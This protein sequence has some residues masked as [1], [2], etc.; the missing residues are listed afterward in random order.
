LFG[1]DKQMMHSWWNKIISRKRTENDSVFSYVI[2]MRRAS[3]FSGFK[4][5]LVKLFEEKVP[6]AAL[7]AGARLCTADSR[8]FTIPSV[9]TISYC[10]WR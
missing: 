7:Q 9:N 8:H 3:R 5:K 2:T 4:E 1:A 10:L 6:S